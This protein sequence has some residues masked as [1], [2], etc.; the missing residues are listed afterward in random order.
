MIFFNIKNIVN[1]FVVVFILSLSTISILFFYDIINIYRIIEFFNLNNPYINQILKILEVK[2]TLAYLWTINLVVIPLWVLWNLKHQNQTHCSLVKHLQSLEN[3]S[4]LLSYMITD[5]WGK[6]YW[7]DNLFKQI[8][9]FYFFK[10]YIGKINLLDVLKNLDE[11]DISDYLKNNILNDIKIKASGSVDLPIKVGSQDSAFRLTYVPIKNDYLWTVMLVQQTQDLSN[12]IFIQDLLVSLPIPM[13]IVNSIGKTMYANSNFYKLFGLQQN[14][15]FDIDEIII[16]KEL[17]HDSTMKCSENMQVC[18][19]LC[20]DSS[21]REFFAYILQEPKYRF[22]TNILHYVR[23]VIVPVADNQENFLNSTMNH[24]QYLHSFSL[25]YKNAPIGMMLVDVNDNII[26]YNKFIADILCLNEV[27]S[28]N[29]STILGNNFVR[30]NKFKN[31]AKEDFEVEFEVKSTIH[32]FRLLMMPVVEKGENLYAVYFIDLTYLRDLESQIKLSQGLQTVGQI[33]SVVAHDFN[34]LLTAIM[35]FTYFAQERQ[36]EDDPS[37]AELE[38]IKQNANRAKIMIKQLLTFSRKQEL[39]PVLFDIN[40][41]ISDLMSTVLRLMGDKIIPSFNRGKHVGQVMMDKVQFQQVITNLVVNAKDSMKH[42]GKLDIVTHGIKLDYSKEGVLGTIPPGTY[43]VVEI[44]DEGDGIPNEH[45]KL[46]FNSHF[47]TKGEKGNGLGLATV[48]KII[49]DSAGFIDVATVVGKGT[50]FFL[51]LPQSDKKVLEE[52]IPVA[53]VPKIK[54]SDLTGSETILLVEDEN[55]VRMV[56]ARLLKSK[57]YNVIEAS[58]GMEAL[59][60]IKGTTALDLVISDVMMPGMSGPE[61]VARVRDSYPNIKA[62]LMSGYAE[63]V[64]ED[65]DGDISLKGIEFL[66]K[67]FTPDVFATKVRAIINS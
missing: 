28:P 30:W 54:R 35:S 10:K 29:M 64:L 32:L 9:K 57:G 51:Y 60:M 47:S 8:F 1:I 65:L 46:I 40:S 55:P 11:I 44:K 21:G 20:K 17:Q 61:L 62:I 53:P 22:N 39:N 49:K 19:C 34:N 4:K 45:L 48:Y 2:N 36:D 26:E 33:A 66:A 27:K 52:D 67:P 3:P 25:L 6:I 37:R 15:S 63:D 14:D 24:M 12:A 18:K 42:G 50:T 13:L 58:G 7:A 16:N 41:E 5:H 23:M 31:N 56:C 43:V 59:E 38:Q